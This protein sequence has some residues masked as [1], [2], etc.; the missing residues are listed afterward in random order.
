MINLWIFLYYTILGV[1]MML[2]FC[3]SRF[4]VRRTG[5]IVGVFTVLLLLAD[6]VIYQRLDDNS[7]M[8]FYPLTNHLPVI[9]MTAYLGRCRGWRLVFQHLSSVLFC[10]LIQHVS[11]LAYIL[12]GRKSWAAVLAYAAATAAVI[13][14]LAGYLRPLYLQVMHHLRRGWFPACL[15]LGTYCAILFCL[16]PS[17]GGEISDFIEIKAFLSFLMVG[18]YT[19]IVTPFSS[20]R[21][22]SEARHNAELFSIQAAALKQ[23]LETVHAA[24]EMIRIERHDLRHRLNTVAA[25]V[26]TGDTEALLSYIGAAQEQLDGERLEHWCEDPLMDAML[27][28]FFKQAQQN[29]IRMDVQLSF[30]KALPVEASG[31]SIVFANALENAIHACRELPEEQRRIV[32][33]CINYPRLML[34]ISNPCA[35]PVPLDAEGFPVPSGE[36]HGFGLRSI[37]SFCQKNNAAVFC[38]NKDGWFSLR[39]AF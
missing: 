35:A 4:T 12:S 1:V 33:R 9:L 18:V 22:E 25:L 17:R 10:C 39:I 11:T 16:L 6:V 14:F 26:Q 13:W 2:F 31:L 23:R 30:P 36:G 37:R 19:M 32:C 28:S 24:E 29:G 27:S 20:V 7:F 15:L 8:R 5:R 3:E 34:E 38:S 21:R